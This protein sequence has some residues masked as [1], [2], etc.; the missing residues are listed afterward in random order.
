MIEENDMLKS[1][2]AK[3]GPS[4]GLLLFAGI[5]RPSM[6]VVYYVSRMMK[7]VAIRS[8]DKLFNKILKNCLRIK[9]NNNLEDLLCNS[10]KCISMLIHI[11]NT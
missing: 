4:Y 5:G 9:K 10:G 1:H 3:I 11:S 2:A 6:E 8:P 7:R